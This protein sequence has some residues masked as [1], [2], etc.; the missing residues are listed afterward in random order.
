[1]NELRAIDEKEHEFDDLPP[2]VDSNIWIEV[3]EG[4]GDGSTAAD[5]SNA[6]KEAELIESVM[7]ELSLV[8][9]SSSYV[10]LNCVSHKV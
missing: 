2:L 6:E 4:D 7:N 9:E 1:M 3:G 10:R 8:Y 5:I